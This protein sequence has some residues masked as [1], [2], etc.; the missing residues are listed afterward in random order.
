MAWKIAAQHLKFDKTLCDRKGIPLAE[1]V[2]PSHAPEIINPW[3]SDQWSCWL[4]TEAPRGCFSARHGIPPGRR[5]GIRQAARIWPGLD[6]GE[7]TLSLFLLSRPG[8]AARALP[9]RHQRS[10]PPSA[11]PGRAPR[12]CRPGPGSP[13]AEGRRLRGQRPAA[14][15]QHPGAGRGFRRHSYF[16]CQSTAAGDVATAGSGTALSSGGLR[17]GSC[18][19]PPARVPGGLSWAHTKSGHLCHGDPPKA[20]RTR[21]RGAWSDFSG[22]HP[23]EG[24]HTLRQ[25]LREISLFFCVPEGITQLR[26]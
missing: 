20:W 1:W 12:R 11:A 2:P 9:L 3:Q 18:C 6:R 26:G 8:G 17:R 21:E 5:E 10:G 7:H 15:R 25:H 23:A 19:T 22:V 14:L 24:C 4:P 16:V 13:A